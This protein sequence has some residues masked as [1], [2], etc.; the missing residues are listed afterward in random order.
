MNHHTN[1]NA[2]E[3]LASQSI[4]LR[5][6]SNG[7]HKA[8]CPQCSHTRK[9]KKDQC[10]SVTIRD[11][12]DVV[13]NCWHCQWADGNKTGRTESNTNY[14][15][16]PFNKPKP[17]D[18][19]QQP[20][21]MIE[22]FK[23][24]GISEA[25]VRKVGVYKDTQ[26]FPQSGKE[27]P[28]IAFPYMWKE[29]LRNVKYRTK[30]KQ[31]RQ[32]KNPEPVLFNADS[33]QPDKDLIFCEGEMDAI[34]FIEAGIENVVSLANGAP[35]KEETSEKRYEPLAIHADELEKV[36]KIYIATDQDGP[37]E[38]LAQELARRLG[39]DRCFRVSFDVTEGV[40]LKDGNEVLQEYG[41][42]ALR[43]CIDYAEP[44][45]VDGIFKVSDFDREVWDLY[46]GKGPRPFSTGFM[47]FDKAF[48]IMP[49]Q[50]VVVSGIPNH[51][52]SRFVDQ[53][54]VQ[55][56]KAHHHKWAIFSP[57]TGDDNHIADLCEIHA[58]KPFYEGVSERMSR[59]EL[60]DA[61]SWVNDN[62]SFISAK[63]HTPTIDWVLER[64]RALVLREGITHLVVDPYN[65][66]E[67]SRPRDQTE[68][69]FVSQLISKCKRFGKLH[70]VTVWMVIHPTKIRAANPGEKE[71]IPGLYDLAGSAHWRNK[72]DA[73]LIVYRDYEAGKTTVFSKKI[74]RQPQ[75]GSPGSVDFSFVGTDRVF[76]ENKD[77]Y[78]SLS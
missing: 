47:E 52:K 66:L 27:E 12:E 68:T 35:Q 72:A 8:T 49:G 55:M 25:T 7:D 45:P 29:E 64:A 20:D 54:A 40:S 63:D 62:F 9:K 10:L 23:N 43:E 75:C 76:E 33:I 36:R 56:A 24:R 1:L 21:T 17:V 16:K 3:W 74:R 28:C 13:V 32:E 11:S 48:K 46:E 4:I 78:R 44:W 18:K 67:A 61:Q 77:S 65:E 71:P 59:D 37:G 41:A 6:T 57:E 26:W 34:S 31:F 14:K 73:G 22:W 50:F 69:E 60:K 5:S 42:K 15:P 58:R 53:V 19:P 38:V 51:G 2:V 30:D 70:G 39:R